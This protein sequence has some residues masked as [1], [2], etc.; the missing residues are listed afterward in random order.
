VQNKF[1]IL[2]LQYLWAAEQ[3]GSI[4]DVGMDEKQLNPKNKLN[5][6][7]RYVDKVCTVIFDSWT[8]LETKWSQHKPFKYVFVLLNTE[9]NHVEI[10]Q[11]KW[12]EAI[13]KVKHDKH[14]LC[15]WRCIYNAWTDTNL[16]TI[17]TL[18]WIN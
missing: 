16:G 17:I 10:V 7:S 8:N 11:F 15:S 3:P 18:Y 1:E 4:T 14:Y 2:P 13:R 9:E 12:P 6:L 5:L